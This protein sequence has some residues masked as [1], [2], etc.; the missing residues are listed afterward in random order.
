[1]QAADAAGAGYASVPLPGGG[2]RMSNGRHW[3]DAARRWVRERRHR[4]RCSGAWM[5]LRRRLRLRQR[6]PSEWQRLG[7]IGLSMR[8]SMRMRRGRGGGGRRRKSH[9]GRG[10]LFENYDDGNLI[11]VDEWFLSFLL[12]FVTISERLAHLYLMSF[13]LVPLCP[14]LLYARRGLLV[15]FFLTFFHHWQE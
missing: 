7:V 8:S 13:F 4:R 9:Y 3:L 2:M 15:F 12:F 6:R 14:L 11:F 1:M 10:R 5:P